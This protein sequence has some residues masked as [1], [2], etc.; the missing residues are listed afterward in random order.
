[1]RNLG[2]GTRSTGGGDRKISRRDLTNHE[3]L[4]P[5]NH[6]AWWSKVAAAFG[7]EKS[8]CSGDIE[9]CFLKKSLCRRVGE[10]NLNYERL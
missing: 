7:G 5:M 10:I 2:E 1:M 4:A 3:N 9:Q 6:G 8:M